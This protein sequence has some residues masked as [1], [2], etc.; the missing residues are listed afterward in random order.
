MNDYSHR[1][2][3]DDSERVDFD[4]DYEIG[5]FLYDENVRKNLSDDDGDVCV[6]ENGRENEMMNEIQLF[7]END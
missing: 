4:L 3:N 6:N 5:G 7:D 1:L 2:D